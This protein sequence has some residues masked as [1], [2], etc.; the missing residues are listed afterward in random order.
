MNKDTKIYASFSQNAGNFGCLFHNYGFKKFNLNCVYKSFSIKNIKEAVRSALCLDFKGFAVSMP[1][2]V[3]VLDYVDILS[4]EVKEIGSANTVVIKNGKLKAYNTDYCSA[5]ETIK[6]I[7]SNKLY[8]LGDGGYAKSVNYATVK[9][10]K[11]PISI[12]RKNWDT[13]KDIKNEYIFNCTPINITVDPSNYYI[14]C[15]IQ[16][17]SGKELSL[18]QASHQFRIYTGLKFALSLNE[19]KELE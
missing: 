4:D 3:E 9:L 12:T 8:I 17:D 10:N 5:Y 18:I 15:L 1:F 7:K 2:K 13:L 11:E 19:F 16:T 6:K 14:D